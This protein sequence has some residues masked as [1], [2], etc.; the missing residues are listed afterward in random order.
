MEHATI[1]NPDGKIVAATADALK[2]NGYETKI[3]N[4][5]R[6]KDSFWDAAI[7]ADSNQLNLLHPETRETVKLMRTM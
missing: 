7:H 4:I 5:K 2:E 1:V 6:S 3:Y